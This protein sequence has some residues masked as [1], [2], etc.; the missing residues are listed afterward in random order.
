MINYE[1][2]AILSAAWLSRDMYEFGDPNFA[3]PNEYENWNPMC[4]LDATGN[5]EYRIYLSDLLE[6]CK[7][8]P[9]VMLWGG[10]GGR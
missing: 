8:Q 6:F 4:S 10:Q 5:S 1:E 2:F 9:Q 7:D 3:D